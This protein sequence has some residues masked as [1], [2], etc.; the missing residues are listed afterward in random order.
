MRGQ[1][2]HLFNT[3]NPAAT[4]HTPNVASK[5]ISRAATSP[6]PSVVIDIPDIPR[7]TITYGVT[8]TPVSKT[9]IPPKHNSCSS[10]GVKCRQTPLQFPKLPRSPTRLSSTSAINSYPGSGR[11]RATGPTSTAHRCCPDHH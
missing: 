2:F 7:H 9:A 5:C 6:S 10:A 8:K 4:K 1:F 3:T 11:T